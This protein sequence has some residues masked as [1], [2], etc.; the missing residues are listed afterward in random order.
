MT[1]SPS[2]RLWTQ[3]L[4]QHPHAG[5]AAPQCANP[6]QGQNRHAELFHSGMSSQNHITNSSH[7]HGGS[8][9]TQCANPYHTASDASKTITGT[10]ANEWLTLIETEKD[11]KMRVLMAPGAVAETIMT[12]RC[13]GYKP[14]PS[15][16]GK[17]PGRTLRRW[18]RSQMHW[19]RLTREP[20]DNWGILL[21]EALD[22]CSIAST[23]A[24]AVHSEVRRSDDGYRAIVVELLREYQP[25]LQLELEVVL[26]HVFKYPKRPH[27]QPFAE[28]IS[29]LRSKLD[30]LDR[31]IAPT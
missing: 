28:F 16:D 30:E 15:Y 21:Y 17:N 11:N 27:R 1:N 5:S 22:Q 23:L 14:C 8:A 12:P 31:Q 29:K 4:E 20:P 3:P 9:A 7:P 25:Y 6:F 19:L 26:L 18:I 13:T 24:H 10:L 2:E